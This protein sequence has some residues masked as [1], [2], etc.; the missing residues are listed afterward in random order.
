MPENNKRGIPWYLFLL[1]PVIAIV[2]GFSITNYILIPYF[3]PGKGTV[4][5]EVPAISRPSDEY[6]LPE[7][8]IYKIQVGA[9]SK[10]ENSERLGN[11]LREDS[12]PAY[13]TQTSPYRVITGIYFDKKQAEDIKDLLIIKG[14]EVYVARKSLWGFSTQD[15]AEMETA[16]MFTKFLVQSGSWW[17]SFYNGNVSHSEWLENGKNIVK[18]GKEIKRSIDAL[19]ESKRTK[20]YNT[21][22]MLLEAALQSF[23]K[24]LEYANLGNINKVIEINEEYIKNINNFLLKWE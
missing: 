1:L 13:I 22:D 18:M 23:D 10:K 7:I 6:F 14:Y 17:Y 20:V 12:M 9:F 3:F 11:R 21:A 5:N 24:A 4:D 19:S 16:E 8:E 2:L 15:K